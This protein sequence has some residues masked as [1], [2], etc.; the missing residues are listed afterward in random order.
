MFAQEDGGRY[1][2]LLGPTPLTTGPA[3]TPEEIALAEKAK[4]PVVLIFFS[5]RAENKRNIENDA[6][7]YLIIMMIIIMIMMLIIIIK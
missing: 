2:A 3:G 6:E 4:Q 1:A 7:I 5:K